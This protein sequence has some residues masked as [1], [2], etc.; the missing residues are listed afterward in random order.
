MLDTP[1]GGLDTSKHMVLARD[2]Y[3]RY[4]PGRPGHEKNTW[5][6]LGTIMLDR[7]GHVHD[8]PTNP[9]R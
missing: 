7:P 6:Q 9:E 4:P 2:N 1:M 5:C 3:V 8:R